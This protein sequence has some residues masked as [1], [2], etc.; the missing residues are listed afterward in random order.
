M[1]VMLKVVY[2]SSAWRGPK[3]HR[4]PGPRCCSPRMGC[5]CKLPFKLHK[6]RRLTYQTQL[7]MILV[8]RIAKWTVDR[9]RLWSCPVPVPVPMGC[10]RKRTNNAWISRTVSLSDRVAVSSKQQ[11]YWKHDCHTWATAAASTLGFWNES[12]REMRATH[13]RMVGYSLCAVEGDGGG[14][15]EKERMSHNL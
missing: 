14:R 5:L 10:G 12:H 11:E 2:P 1:R 6:V 7:Y 3:V 4:G 13:E 9:R 15:R 8:P